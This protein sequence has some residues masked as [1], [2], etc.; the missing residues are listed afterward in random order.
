MNF[1]TQLIKKISEK[2]SILCI[3]IDMDPDRIEIK[4]SPTLEDLRKYT[5]KVIDATLDVA[6]AYKPN[7]AFFE[8]WGSKGYQW[9]EE[10]LEYIGKDSIL[11]CDAKRGDIGNT[12]RQYAI[13]IFDHFGFDAVT[14]SPYMGSDSISPFIER[15]EKGVFVLCLTSNPGARELQ[16]LRAD[17]KPVYMNVI[18]MVKRLNANRNCGLV[19]GATQGDE[20]AEV[21]RESGNL[22]FLIPG[23]GA[24]GGDLEVAVKEGN[25]D[26]VAIINVSRSILYAGDQSEGAIRASARN[27]QEQMNDALFDLRRNL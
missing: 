8:R 2:K 11:I 10:M 21:R 16:L 15:P 14:V 17:G 12:A 5:L 6:V 27:F 23:I 18:K 7:M 13:S 3:G 20:I 4:S 26:G 25:R 9:L 22:P 24:Q 19:V 1:T